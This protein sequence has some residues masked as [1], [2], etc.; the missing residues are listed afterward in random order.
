LLAEL[1]EDEIED[2]DVEEQEDGDGD[3]MFKLSFCLLV[4]IGI[5]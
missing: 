2:D 1:D 5:L 3:D 4:T